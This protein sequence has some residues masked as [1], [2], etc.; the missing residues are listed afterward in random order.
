MSL[1]Y[2]LES[3]KVHPAL[4][5]PAYVN[6]LTF[7]P[8]KPLIIIPQ[9]LS[10]LTGPVYGH[11]DVRDSEFDLTR[12][13]TGA[14]MG[15]R[16]IVFGRVLDEDGRGVPNTLVEIWQ[17]NASGRYI[18]TQ[19]DSAPPLDPNFDGAGRVVTDANGAYKFMTIKPG[20]Y[21]PGKNARWWRPA[22]IHLS[23]FGTSFTSRLV[24]QMYFPG[25]PL[26]Q[27]DRIFQSVHDKAAQNRLVAA[28]DLDASLPGEALAYRFDFVLRG[29][30]ATPQDND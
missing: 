29:R 26:Q 10:E 5:E 25:D 22:H 6:S 2:P 13:H 1:T 4:V 27:F 28:L 16:I 3:T 24:T 18:H 23:L 8:K 11:D 17:A 20:A 9:T 12:Q 15:E 14:P 30:H 19:D 7:G 21:A